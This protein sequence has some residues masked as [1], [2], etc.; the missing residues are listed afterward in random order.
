M[1]EKVF[2]MVD[3]WNFQARAFLQE[4][5]I[6]V[7]TNEMQRILYFESGGKMPEITGEDIYNKLTK[8]DQKRVDNVAEPINISG[9]RGTLE[10]SLKGDSQ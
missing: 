4:E 10:V 6:I 8:R 2:V 3:V 9:I 1:T 7:P 5:N